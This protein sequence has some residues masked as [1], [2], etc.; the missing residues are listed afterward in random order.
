MGLP[1]RLHPLE[2]EAPLGRAADA[3]GALG[4]EVRLHGDAGLLGGLDERGRVAEV[5]VVVHDPV[6]EQQGPLERGGGLS[7]RD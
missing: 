6:G 4:V 7:G 3:V 1:E 5:D 2:E